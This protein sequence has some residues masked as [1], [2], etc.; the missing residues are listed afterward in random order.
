MSYEHDALTEQ[1]IGCAYTVAN[2]LS[3]LPIGVYRCSSVVKTERVF[4]A[5]AATIVHASL[6]GIFDEAINL[7]RLLRSS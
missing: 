6:R 5:V 7:C 1:I 3:G 2:T 4:S